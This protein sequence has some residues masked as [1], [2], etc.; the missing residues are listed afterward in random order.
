MKSVPK[1]K[2]L[3]VDDHAIVRDGLIAILALQTDFKVIGEAKDGLD[4]I[5]KVRELRPDVIIMDM[6]MPIM[7]GL[8]ATQEIIKVQKSAKILLLTSY[9]T[10]AEI[11]EAL[12]IGAIGAISKT[13]PKDQLFAAIRSIATSQRTIS[14]EIEQALL[15]SKT[16]PGLSARQLEI[17]DSL[18]RGLTNKDIAKQHGLSIAGVKFHLLSI[19]RKLNVA[20]RSEAVSFA[21][22]NHLLKI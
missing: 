6:M 7:N 3:L 20:N 16:S 5:E 2:I 11:A 13:A 22:K 17:L 1:I 9:G 14:P 21:L 12:S 15:S 4:A 10:S 19:F 8:Q 18:C